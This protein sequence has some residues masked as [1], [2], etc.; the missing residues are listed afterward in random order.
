MYNIDLH[1]SPHKGEV[2]IADESTAADE[3]RADEITDDSEMTDDSETTNDSEITDDG[4]TDD[5]LTDDGLTDDGL[6]ADSESKDGYALAST[7][8]SNAV[9]NPDDCT[10][11]YNFSE[12]DFHPVTKQ[13]TK[14][15]SSVAKAKRLA[16]AAKQRIYYKKWRDRMSPEQ[17]E[18]F[19]E[20]TR[21]AMRKWRQENPEKAKRTKAQNIARRPQNREY[22]RRRRRENPGI[23]K[24]LYDALPEEKK[25]ERRARRAFT[26][27]ERRAKKRALNPPKKR[28]ILRKN[29]RRNERRALQRAVDPF[30]KEKSKLQSRI[31]RAKAKLKQAKGDPEKVK[32]AE[33][34]LAIAE[35]ERYELNEG[36]GCRS[37]KLPSDEQWQAVKRHRLKSI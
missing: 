14:V 19:Q 29:R 13:A 22:Q 32:E 35:V 27:R 10:W 9:D 21:N 37:K 18:R 16:A 3:S 5:G 8:E 33:L 11:E 25:A 2:T 6:T 23:D 17:V 30:H 28:K 36:I 26:A 24:K 31:L 7:S 20:Y 1:L 34:A 4:L 12:D 15:E